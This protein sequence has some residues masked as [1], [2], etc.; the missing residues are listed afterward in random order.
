MHF[1]QDENYSVGKNWRCKSF[2]TNVTAFSSR[3]CRTTQAED[4]KDWELERALVQGE[5]PCRAKTL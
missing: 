1:I 3:H 2:L 5:E 4:E